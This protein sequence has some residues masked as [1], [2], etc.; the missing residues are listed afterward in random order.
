MA[1]EK[2]HT[3]A[4]LENERRREEN[5]SRWEN[6]EGKIERKDE[7]GAWLRSIFIY[8]CRGIEMNWGARPRAKINHEVYLDH[9]RT[10]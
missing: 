8:E 3:V 7:S 9:D 5:N 10:R 4:R 6:R 1:F 2:K